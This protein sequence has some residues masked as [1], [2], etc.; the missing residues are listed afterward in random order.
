MWEVGALMTPPPMRARTLF[1]AGSTG[2]TGRTLLRLA[3]ATVSLLPHVR[4]GGKR[5]GGIDPR[6]LVFD[7]ADAGALEAALA[8]CT[9]VL[10]LIGTMRKRF[11]NGDTY[12]S[13]DVATTR[14]LAL[15]AKRAGIDHFVLLSSVGAGRPMGA[16]L[17]AK[18]R[19]EAIVRE[20]GLPR[21][22]LRPSSFVGE[23]HAP[24]PGMKTLTRLLGLE[25]YE[26]IAIED[27]AAA[28]LEVAIARAPLE[29]VLEGASLL[30]VV[31]RSRGS[32]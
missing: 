30:A 4:P 2:A 15:A 13:S 1:V 9:T 27:L 10:Q 14:H 16:Y 25:R 8:R 23:G 5:D 29:T 17:A 28:I 20:S 18:A 12:E 32:A 11:A 24:P 21:T 19:A 7:L 31:R 6:A 26:P 3:P 22:I